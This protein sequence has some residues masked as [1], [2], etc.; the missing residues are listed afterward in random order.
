MI[1]AFPSTTDFTALNASYGTPFTVANQ[2]EVSIVGCPNIEGESLLVAEVI[3]VNAFP[4]V[5]TD[6]RV[7][8]QGTFSD[9]LQAAITAGTVPAAI[10]TDA[11][12]AALLPPPPTMPA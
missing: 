1:I 7:A 3:G 11:E 10:L 8:L 4:T 5:L 9:S 6:G 2:T 12:L